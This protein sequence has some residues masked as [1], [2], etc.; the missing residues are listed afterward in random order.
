MRIGKSLFAILFALPAAAHAEADID[1]ISPGNVS[2]QTNTISANIVVEVQLSEDSEMKNNKML[3]AAVKDQGDRDKI[4]IEG[5][6]NCGPP[7]TS[8]PTMSPS[9]GPT[10]EPTDHPTTT[11]PTTTPTLHP[12]ICTE[13]P[14]AIFFLRFNKKENPIFKKCDWLKKND[15]FEH[16][17]RERTSSCKKNKSTIGPAME[18]CMNTCDTCHLIHPSE[19]PSAVPSSEPTH[20]PTGNPTHIPTK[21]PTHQPSEGPSDFPSQRPTTSPTKEP[22]KSPTKMP[23]PLPTPEPTSSPTVL[24]TNSPTSEP[25]NA[26]SEEPSDTPTM[27]P[28]LYPS[29][30]PSHKPTSMPSLAPSLHLSMSP[31]SEPSD[32]P[33]SHPTT[34]PENASALFFL[35]YRNGLPVYQTCQWLKQYTDTHEVCDIMIDSCPETNIGPAREVCMNTC[36]TCFL[37]HP[38]AA[39]SPEPTAH[40]T[41]LPTKE[42]TN[43]PTMSPTLQNC[44]QDSHAVFFLNYE[45]NGTPLF[46]TCQ[47]LSERAEFREICQ[48][49]NSCLVG[50]AI[51]GPAREICMNTCGSCYL[52]H[53]SEAPSRF[54]SNNPTSQPTQKPTRNPTRHPT[55]NPTRSPI[56]PT[57][58]IGPSKGYGNGPSKGGK[59]KGGK[60]HKIHSFGFNWSTRAPAASTRA[61]SVEES[62]RA[63]AD[64]SFH[65]SIPS[66]QTIQRATVRRMTKRK[67]NYLTK[68]L[69]NKTPK[70]SKSSSKSPHSK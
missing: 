13:D 44:N 49:S 54:P 15:S 42:P 11:A 50:N 65:S 32:V 4:S 3:G 17:C 7:P 48:G 5:C 38:S 21:S 19:T 28:T 62:T 56:H 34:C 10:K 53:P 2:R 25:S 60:K 20:K 70:S 68:A 9:K 39:P 40:P 8:S 61:P 29:M 14:H 33:S 64:S 67:D 41:H 69:L 35:Q 27:L 45:V 37:M 24:P 22:T 66:N 1:E 30:T 58:P 31:S 16:I 59:G 55:R 63:P 6:D 46:R 57:R 51:I 23:T 36:D 47:W 26:P 18:V 12:T 43:V 52:M